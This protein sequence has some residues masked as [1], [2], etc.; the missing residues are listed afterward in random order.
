V[1]VA[2]AP[3]AQAVGVRRQ[4][5][6]RW[7]PRSRVVEIDVPAF[8]QVAVLPGAQLVQSSGGR[9]RRVRGQKKRAGHAFPRS[10]GFSVNPL[11]TM[12]MS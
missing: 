7:Q 2:E 1:R 6:A 10:A 4:L 11:K 5:G 3:L 9:V 12:Y 8:V